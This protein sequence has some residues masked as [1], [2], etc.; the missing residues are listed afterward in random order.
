MKQEQVKVEE[1]LKRK[2]AELVGEVDELTPRIQAINTALGS[3]D[4]RIPSK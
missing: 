2:R 1:E 4:H 3:K